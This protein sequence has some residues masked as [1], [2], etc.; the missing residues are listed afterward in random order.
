MAVWIWLIGA[1]A[2]AWSCLRKQR[3]F[4]RSL[5]ALRAHDDGLL[6][7]EASAGLP[8]VV[9]LRHRVVV[10]ADF[11]TRYGAHEQILILAH[12]RVHARRRDMIGNA[13]AALF[14]CLYWFNPLM[15]YAALRFRRD[16]ELACDEAVVAQY[17]QARRAYEKVGFN[18][19]IPSIYM[20]R[21]L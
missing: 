19:H 3:A 17:P 9:G 1:A 16:Q 7:A 5:G 21:Q 4:V 6:Q 20:Y 13:C 14:R 8:A 12:E 11:Y 15:S 18:V 2:A 10:P